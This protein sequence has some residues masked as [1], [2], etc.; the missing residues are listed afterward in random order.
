MYD[1]VSTRSSSTN[2]QQAL[3]D[4]ATYRACERRVE[5]SRRRRWTCSTSPSEKRDPL[6]PSRHRYIYNSGIRSA[7]G[8]P[9]ALDASSIV[10]QVG[11]APAN[12]TADLLDL[13][14]AVHFFDAMKRR[15]S[16][17]AAGDHWVRE[18]EFA[19]AVRDLGKWS[20]PSIASD[21]NA[22]LGWFTDDVWNIEFVQRNST[23]LDDNGQAFL[24]NSPIEGSCISLYSGGLDSFAGLSLDL[25]SGIEPILVSAVSNNRQRACQ[26]AT[27][28]AVQSL[29]NVIIPHVYVDLH[30]S[31]IAASES[32]QRSR[33]FCFLAIADA[34]AEMAKIDEIRVYENG[35]GAINLPYSSA[36]VGA[37]ATRSM[38]PKSLRLSSAFFSELLQRSITIINPNRL[39]TKAEMCGMLPAVLHQAVPITRSCDM[40]FAHRA[41][42]TASCGFC[43]SCLLRRQALWATDLSAVDRQTACRVDVLAEQPLGPHES[44]ALKAMLFQA[45][46]IRT[47]LASK[48]PWRNLLLEFPELIDIDEVLG[49]EEL[50]STMRTRLMEMY[51]RYVNE[52]RAFPIDM[53]NAYVDFSEKWSI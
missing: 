48:D 19:L 10:R 12:V 38:H 47:A 8:S 46:K 14:A 6:A 41:S 52:W 44:Y 29:L 24:F 27:V 20:D 3:F 49:Q 15:P 31:Q 35:I 32:S 53:A 9:R 5:E 50:S 17:R 36:Q 33:G 4:V 26:V 22:L 18:I 2:Y 28:K 40:A 51:D 7:S 39:R 34:V 1:A 45:E 42:K 13:I 25:V 23:R 37:Q 16:A 11:G 43:T 21:L 30:L